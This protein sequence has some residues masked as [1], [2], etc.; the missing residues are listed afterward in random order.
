MYT[1]IDPK[2]HFMQTWEARSSEL[3]PLPDVAH[4]LFLHSSL[5]SLSVPISR[6]HSALRPLVYQRPVRQPRPS[7]RNS[8]T[9][10]S[11]IRHR[12]E[13]ANDRCLPKSLEDDREEGTIRQLS[14]K[15]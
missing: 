7:S 13:C 11:D 15:T 3:L 4:C 2:L 9:H 10:P 8:L 6:R 5:F 14:P 12:Q 1:L